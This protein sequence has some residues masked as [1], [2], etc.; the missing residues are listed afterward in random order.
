DTD[1]VMTQRYF[2]QRAD[3]KKHNAFTDPSGNF[4]HWYTVLNPR[5]IEHWIRMKGTNLVMVR[6]FAKL[7]NGWYLIYYAGLRPNSEVAIK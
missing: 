6:R 2:W 1:T 3:W 4:E 5:I 7:D